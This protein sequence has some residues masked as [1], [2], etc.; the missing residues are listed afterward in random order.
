MANIFNPI[1]RTLEIKPFST[2]NPTPA[3]APGRAIVLAGK[4]QPL[5]VIRHGE[6]GGPGF[7]QLFMGAYKWFYEVDMSAQQLTFEELLQSKDNFFA[8]R[9]SINLTCEVSDPATIVANN[10]TDA[11]RVIRPLIGKAVNNLAADYS[12]EQFDQFK[13]KIDGGV[14]FVTPAGFLVRH[15]ICNVSLTKEAER[16][17]SARAMQR[18]EHS[19]MFEQ[20]QL[21]HRIKDEK[22][23]R[24]EGI[25]QKGPEGLLA[26]YLANDPDEKILRVAEMLTNQRQREQEMLRL[27]D[28]ITDPL[29]RDA[30]IEKLTGKSVAALPS[31]PSV[32][33]EQNDQIEFEPVLD[34]EE[35]MP[36]DFQ[37]D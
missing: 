21:D 23:R 34:D 20:T 36:E 31:G 1:L 9:A 7:G 25:I 11:L 33:N 30:L 35:D 3:P 16:I 2:S 17:A 14:S 5:W 15:F 22:A 8:F 28:K 19:K 29:V 6:G 32:T 12:L 27:T 13:R 4:N 24:V 18:I 10:I 37:R 26:E